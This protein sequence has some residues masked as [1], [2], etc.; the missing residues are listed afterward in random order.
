MQRVK[1]G[2]YGLCTLYAYMKMKP[3][4]IVLSKEGE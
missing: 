4:E 1:E 3:V 2:E